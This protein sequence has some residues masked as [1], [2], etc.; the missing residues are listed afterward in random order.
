MGCISKP[1]GCEVLNMN[2]KLASYSWQVYCGDLEVAKFMRV[3]LISSV[4]L[5]LAKQW[6]LRC[7]AYYEECQVAA[8]GFIPSRL[9]DIGVEEDSGP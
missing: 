3:S 1:R 2:K 5:S 8:T 4:R 7:G 6:I 9:V